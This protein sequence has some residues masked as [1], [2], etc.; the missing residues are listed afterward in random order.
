MDSS[1]PDVPL[2]RKLLFRP[3]EGSI[4]TL[5]G[6]VQA[7]NWIAAFG[8]LAL[9]FTFTFWRLDVGQWN[10]NVLWNYR[11]LF[12]TGFGVTIL[13]SIASLLASTLIGLVFALAGRSSFLPLRSITKIYVE[14][15]RGTPLLSQILIFFYVVAPAMNVE[16]RYL[17]GVMTLSFFSG[18]YI[19]EIIRSGIEGIA[20]SQIESARAIGLTTAQTYRFVIFPQAFKQVLPPLAG[21][22]V[23]LIKDS[24][25]LSVISVNEFTKNAQQ[26]NSITYS[27]LECYLFL[28]VGYLFLTLPISLLTRWLESRNKFDT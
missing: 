25:L 14:A 26:V 17:V 9:F 2:W 13:I 19:S 3:R 1:A 27:T 7:I 11:T 16:N 15:V 18:A 21:Q 22:F 20:K 8:L 24:S 6:W 4:E 23:S 28:A 12:L 5:P 10:W